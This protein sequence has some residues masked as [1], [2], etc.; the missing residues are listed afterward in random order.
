[1][2]SLLSKLA[3]LGTTAAQLDLPDGFSFSIDL[4]AETNMLKYDVTIP[5]NTYLGLAYGRGMNN[6]DM[7][8]FSAS[9]F[10]SV[11]DHW[12]KSIGAPPEDKQND[13]MNTQVDISGGS[14]TFTTYRDLVTSDPN[15]EDYQFET[16]DPLDMQ[17]VVNENTAELK[18]HNKAGSFT[19]TISQ[20]GTSAVIEEDDSSFYLG[21]SAI[22]L[23]SWA[24]LMM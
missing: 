19:L 16:F 7:V 12:S 23:A 11:T 8:V 2:S 22:A 13:Y 10:G 14:Y 9:G 3:L 4:D 20:D 1:M 21:A 15:G 5:E 24:T 17:W 6:V 18:K